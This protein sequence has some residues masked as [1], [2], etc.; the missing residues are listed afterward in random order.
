M[1][2]VRDGGFIAGLK[3]GLHRF[4]PRSG[5]FTLIK[6]VEPP[7]LDNRLNDGF[8]DSSGR[9]WFGSMH[10]PE[11]KPSGVLYRFDRDGNCIP[12]DAGY[13][14]TNGPAMSPD[15]RTLYH[16]DTLGQTIYAFDVASDG[17]LSRKRVF[18]RIERPN[19]YP[20]GPVVDRDGYLWSGLFGGWGLV[21]FSPQGQ[22][23]AEIRLPCANVIRR[24]S[25][26][27][28][29]GPYTSRPHGSAWMKRT[30][31][32]SRRQAR[33]SACASKR[34]DCRRTKCICS[35]SRALREFRTRSERA[36]S[37]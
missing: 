7:E 27:T 32:R 12:C 30:A 28:I 29:F 26:A 14:V 31:T 23:V 21:R 3:T 5:R 37:R 8:V 4:D 13:C 17:T 15:G 25:A 35:A 9:L 24:R 6:T 1:L 22:V 10:D 36:T 16:V 34:R 33:C 18:A 2:P 11:T 19:V 20:D